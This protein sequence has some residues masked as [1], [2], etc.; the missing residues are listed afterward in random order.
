MPKQIQVPDA[1]IHHTLAFVSASSMLAKR[2]LDELAVHR[3]MQKKAADSA[4]P[5]LEEM[6]REGVVTEG[7]RKAAAMM[8]GDHPRSLDLLKAAT[9]KIVELRGE[10]TKA[11]E[12]LAHYGVKTEPGSAV[13]DPQQK[14][15][16]A[17]PSE[18]H[19]SLT[20][21]FVGQRTDELKASDIALMKSAGMA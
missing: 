1:L 6:V 10:L 15:A 7:H 12:K 14:T 18:P 20:S 2:A 5:L 4:G 3:D 21:V 17:S 19:A 13:G 16:G 8:L 9:D 11:N